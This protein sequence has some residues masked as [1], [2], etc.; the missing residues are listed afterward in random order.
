[1]PHTSVRPGHDVTGIDPVVRAARVLIVDDEPNVRFVFRTALESSGSRSTR[2]TSGLAAL[3]RLRESPAD[4]V[5]LDLQMPG[6]GGM[7]VLRRLR[8]AGDDVPV[9]IVTAHGSVPDAVAAMRLGA[10]DFLAKPLTPEAL[11]D[12]SPRSSRGTRRR[13]RSPN[14]P[15][16]APD[17]RRV[18]P[19]RP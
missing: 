16:N 5:L 18:E 1:M 4:V 19:D 3:Q 8:D 17:R 12:W 14:R 13:G 15:T 2:R 7:E 10:I 6:I 9:V 11:A